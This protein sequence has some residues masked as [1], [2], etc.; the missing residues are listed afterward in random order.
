MAVLDHRRHRRRHR[1]NSHDAIDASRNAEASVDDVHIALRRGDRGR[2]APG[3]SLFAGDRRGTHGN[4]VTEPESISFHVGDDE[5]GERL[6]R[7]VARHVKSG[8]RKTADLFQRG[9]VR[10]GGRI[11]KKGV[12]AKRGEEVTVRLA[13]L[14]LPEPDL[15]LDVRLET[16]Y[17]VVANKPAGQPT[18]PAR[19]GDAGALAG[20]AADTEIMASATAHASGAVARLDT[21]IGLVVAADRRG[22]PVSAAGSARTHRKALPRSR[23]RFR[24]A[25]SGMIAAGSGDHATPAR[26]PDRRAP[27][28]ASPRVT[29]YRT[30]RRARGHWSRSLLDT[31]TGIGASTSRRSDTPSPATPCTAALRR[32]CPRDATHCTR[33]T[34]RGPARPTFPPSPSIA[35]RPPTSR[36]SAFPGDARSHSARAA[37]AQDAA[38]D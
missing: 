37:G 13:P 22:I 36:R 10:V 3:G 18:A 31:L 28:T 15:P 23:A 17:V 5:D 6:D 2:D 30:L 7:L 8:R 26:R 21:H 27:E 32:R 35:R 11:V 12:L 19:D 34:W 29:H 25:E 33:A 1:G 38:R 16:T 4:V 24:A 9:A 20:G 14:I